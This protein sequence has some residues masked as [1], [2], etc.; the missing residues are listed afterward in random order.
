MPLPANSSEFKSP[1]PLPVAAWRKRRASWAKKLG[2][3]I[4]RVLPGA[5]VGP[6]MGRCVKPMKG[7]VAIPFPGRFWVTARVR[8]ALEG[9]QV[10][11]LS[12]SEVLLG[13]ECGT[14]KLWELVVAGHAWRKGTDPESSIECRIC[15]LVGFPDP[16]VLSVDT[17]RWDGS[18]LFTL[19]YNPNIV[20]T[21][22]RV[23]RILQDLKLRGL[24]VVPVD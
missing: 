18:D 23:A 16:E 6:P 17:T 20:V 13:K 7:D 9:A 15:G 3:S 24:D 21:T 11:G 22:E 2:V 19:D 10:T 5:T 14:L 4:D 12:F 1:E 8:D